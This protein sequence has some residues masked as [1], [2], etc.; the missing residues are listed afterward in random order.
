MNFV[1][2]N[3]NTIIALG[4][5]L[6]VIILLIQVKNIFFPD[7][8]TAIYG[9]RLEGIEKVKISASDKKDKIQESLGDN[10]SNITVRESGKIINIILTVNDETSVEDAKNYANKTMESFSDAEKKYYDFQIFIEKKADSDN[11]PIIGYRH[12]GKD[13]FTWTKDR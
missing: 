4:V 12:H 13:S 2:R 8:N 9:N 10:A 5:F 6:I 7:E 1:K 11:F 3:K